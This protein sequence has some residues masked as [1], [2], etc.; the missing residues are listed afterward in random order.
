MAQTGLSGLNSPFSSPLKWIK[1][2][3]IVP[4]CHPIREVWEIYPHVVTAI[5][6]SYKKPAWVNR[7]NA[8][9]LRPPTL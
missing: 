4:T 2:F 5:P 3:T 9:P 8:Y 6:E 7:K 1:A